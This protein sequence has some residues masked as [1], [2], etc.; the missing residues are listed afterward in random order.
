LESVL[1]GLTAPQPESAWLARLAALPLSAASPALAR[2]VVRLRCRAASLVANPR[3]ASPVLDTCDPDPKGRV[4]RLARLELLGRAPLRGQ[5]LVQFRELATSDDVVVRERALELL[6]D[7]TEV[8][9]AFSF[10]T[11]ALGSKSPGEVATAASV[12]HK[13]PARAGT[14]PEASGEDASDASAAEIMPDPALVNALLGAIASYGKSYNVEVTTALFDA[15]AALQVLGAKPAL[16]AACKNSNPTLRARAEAALRTLGE[17]DRACNDFEPDSALPGELASLERAK[18]RLTFETDVGSLSIDLD[19]E[20]APVAVGRAVALAQ[21]GFYDAHAVHRVVPGFVV[22]FGDPGGDGYGGADLPPLRCETAPAPFEPGAVGVALSGRDTGSSQ[23]F[24]TLGRH[25]H[26]GGNY[27]L[28]GQASAGWD[29]L[30]EGDRI[31]K[32]RVEAVR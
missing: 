4:G 1:Y 25:P 3:K 22:Q 31:V 10:F 13:H 30:A 18:Q 27:A 21:K 28:V 20:L 23:L 9:D 5:R 32:V 26:L 11:R 6:A 12:L 19:A 24:V 17:R 7:Q 15:A 14:N 29:R 8:R 2:R 16:E